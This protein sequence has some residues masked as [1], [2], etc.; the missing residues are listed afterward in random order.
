MDTVVEKV[1]MLGISVVLG[2]A[3]ALGLLRAALTGRLNDESGSFGQTPI[4]KSDLPGDIDWD[5]IEVRD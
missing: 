1:A 5:T 4:S 3:A 2:A